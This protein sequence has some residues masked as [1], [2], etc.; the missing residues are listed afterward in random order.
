MERGTCYARS[1]P[2]KRKR[3]LT[4]LARAFVEAYA[5]S[6]GNQTQAAIKAGYSPHSA[7][8]RASELLARE[9][10]QRA[11]R[12]HQERVWTP[13]QIDKPEVIGRLADIVRSTE[14]SDKD[15][16]EAARTIGRFM[17]WEVRR[18][19]HTG[20]GGG[21]VVTADLETMRRL[22]EDPKM[23]PA[24]MTLARGAARELPASTE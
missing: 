3:R 8:Q 9:D 14:A 20:P 21:P 5:D 18:H 16:V 10:V 7:K 24:V 11:I 2:R 13:R 17:G 12:E 22:L 19:E 1:V 6:P 15:R 23:R 4:A